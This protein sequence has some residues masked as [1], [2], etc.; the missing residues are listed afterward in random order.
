MLTTDLTNT[1]QA[2]APTPRHPD[3]P[4]HHQHP[5]HPSCT[6][7]RQSAAKA[8]SVLTCLALHPQS[9]FRHDRLARM[10]LDTLQAS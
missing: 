5:G 1:G 2:S 3:N 4:Q 7:M 10:R 8:A 9:A 6:E